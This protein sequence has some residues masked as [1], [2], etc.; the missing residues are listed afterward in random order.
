MARSIRE[1][2]WFLYVIECLNGA[3]YTG[4]TNDLAKRFITHSKGRGAVYTR[5]NK[6]LRV[7][8]CREYP[9]KSIAAKAEAQLK[10]CDRD[11]KFAWAEV[12]PPPAHL[13]DLYHPELQ[14]ILRQQLLEEGE[15]SG[16]V[17]NI[18]NDCPAL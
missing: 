7:L 13:I 18:E 16:T 9:N 8:A 5:I 11:F 3:L 6:P 17:S 10:K 15:C 14:R 1:Q 12:N 4:I 2:I